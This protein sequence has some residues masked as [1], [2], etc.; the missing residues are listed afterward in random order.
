MRQIL[1]LL[2]FALASIATAC[3]SD[4]ETDPTG[5]ATTT[6]S[7]QPS[8]GDS[9]TAI[10]RINPDCA[11][12]SETEALGWWHAWEREPP[13]WQ[14]RGEIEGTLTIERIGVPALPSI[15]Y[16]EAEG[17]RLKMGESSESIC[18]GWPPPTAADG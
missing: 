10:L 12:A 3:G 11:G 18:E 4:V 7:A 8:A 14:F 9:A 2:A 6:D 5:A 16:F 17:H 13:E 1:L 15:A